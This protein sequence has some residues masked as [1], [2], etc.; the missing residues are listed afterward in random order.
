MNIL[1]ISILTSQHWAVKYRWQENEGYVADAN[2]AIRSD[3]LELSKYDK[4]GKDKINNE[5]Q[6]KHVLGIYHR[7][8]A[9]IL[10]EELAILWC[11]FCPNLC[12]FAASYGS[13]TFTERNSKNWWR[14]NVSTKLFIYTF[15]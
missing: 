2:E 5:L 9:N 8:F 7:F 12:K 1:P 3:L 6:C 11:P 10:G 15:S 4:E 14:Y 13:A